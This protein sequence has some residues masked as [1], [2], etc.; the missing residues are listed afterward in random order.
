MKKIKNFKV[1]WFS[2]DL[3]M[4]DFEIVSA[5]NESEAFEKVKKHRSITFDRLCPHTR[6]FSHELGHA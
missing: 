1:K 2:K 4:S 6:D 3:G 5:K